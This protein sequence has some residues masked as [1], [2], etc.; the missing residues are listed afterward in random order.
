MDWLKAT[1]VPLL[2]ITF[3]IMLILGVVA[4]VVV[5]N[6]RLRAIVSTGQAIRKNDTASP[7]TS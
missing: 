5:G 4:W 3:L 6:A 2:G 7:I 1:V